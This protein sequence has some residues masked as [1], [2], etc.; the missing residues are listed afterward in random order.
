VNQAFQTSA[1]AAAIRSIRSPTVPTM[2]GTDK[3]AG[4]G[5][6]THSLAW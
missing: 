5:N 3:R 6:S 4:G 1:W 2:I